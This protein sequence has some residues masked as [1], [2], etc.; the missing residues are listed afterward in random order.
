MARRTKEEAEKTRARILANAL[1]LFTKKGYDHTTFT[2]IAAR[3]KMTKGAVYWH[4]KS[5]DDLLA[6]ILNEALDYFKTK[7]SIYL[8]GREPSLKVIAQKMIEDAVLIVS[9][10]RRRDFFM[11]V[12]RKIEWTDKT[13][14]EI[15]AKLKKER[16]DG[17]YHTFINAVEN[18]KKNGLVSETV[19]PCEVASTSMAIWEGLILRHIEGFLECDL[20]ETLTDAFDVIWQGIKKEKI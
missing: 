11:L 3:L 19:N 10:K 8:E 15:V 18:D 17:P 9:N 13:V 20:K 2:D 16:S 1:T 7:L 12:N 4:F 14:A 5:K 6:A